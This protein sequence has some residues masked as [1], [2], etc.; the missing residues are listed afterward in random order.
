METRTHDNYLD[1]AFFV[2]NYLSRML[3]PRP[4]MIR[5]DLEV[6]LLSSISQRSVFT[7]SPLLCALTIVEARNIFDH[8]V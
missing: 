3:L 2:P 8:Q 4:G 1:R 6:L 5:L 7:P